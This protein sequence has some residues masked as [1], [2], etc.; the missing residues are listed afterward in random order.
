MLALKQRRRRTLKRLLHGARVRRGEP[1]VRMAAPNARGEL[2]RT[3]LHEA[4][5]WGEPAIVGAVLQYTQGWELPWGSEV[6]PRRVASY[7]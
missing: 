5:A 1:R 3:A 2:G 4:A 6:R 7:R